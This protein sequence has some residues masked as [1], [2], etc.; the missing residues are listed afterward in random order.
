L[1]PEPVEGKFVKSFYEDTDGL[2]DIELIYNKNGPNSN[3]FISGPPAMIKAV[4]QT[5]ITKGVQTNN[6][7]TDDWK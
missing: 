6:I 1:V 3:Y 5:L 4:K 7:L 2:I